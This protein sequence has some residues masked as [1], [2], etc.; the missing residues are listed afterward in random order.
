MEKARQQGQR[1]LPAWV[2]EDE[3]FRLLLRQAEKLVK[4]AETR[5]LVCPGAENLTS[6]LFP[7]DAGGA[8]AGETGREDDESRGQG[9]P[10]DQ[11]TEPQRG[12]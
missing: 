10:Q 5:V 6:S 3:R 7:S 9:R 11:R 8:A 4:T 2:Q 12:P 1:Q